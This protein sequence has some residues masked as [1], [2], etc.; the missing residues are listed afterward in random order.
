MI[1]R[2]TYSRQMLVADSCGRLIPQVTGGC[3]G[4]LE[5]LSGMRHAGVASVFAP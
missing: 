1:E 3:A 4:E 2:P 5:W